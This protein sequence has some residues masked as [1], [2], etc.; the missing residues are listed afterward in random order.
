MKPFYSQRHSRFLGKAFL[1][2]FGVPHD[3]N[4]RSPI[5]IE[6]DDGT[7]TLL[8]RHVTRFRKRAGRA[9]QRRAPHVRRQNR[10]SRVERARR[11]PQRTATIT[12]PN[13]LV[14]AGDAF[15]FLIG[16]GS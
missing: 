5:V 9:E 8:G 2:I 7:Q 12:V 3:I 6:N 1:M 4:L 14:H 11:M 10:T 15:R 16:G 13:L